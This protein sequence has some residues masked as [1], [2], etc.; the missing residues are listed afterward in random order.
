MVVETVALHIM[1][2]APAKHV[3]VIPI[4]IDRLAKP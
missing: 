1:P 4:E 2:I 3:A